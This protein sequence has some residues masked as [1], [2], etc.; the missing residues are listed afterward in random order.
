MENEAPFIT[1]ALCTHNH[2]DRLETTLGKINS[3]HA[4][5]LKWEFL[6]ID[7]AST[8][9]TARLLTSEIW[10]P[11][12]VNVRIIKEDKLGLSNARNR[13]VREARGDYVLFL[14]DDETPDLA[15][16][17]EYEKSF[18]EHNPDAVGGKISV[19]FEEGDRPRWLLDELLGFLG[20][21]DYGELRWLTEES[22]RICGGNF[23]I[24]RCVPDI[25]GDF[26]Q[27]L[28]RTGTS[29]VGGEDTDFYRRMVAQGC[30]VLWN[31]AAIIHHRI[32]ASKLR[33]SYFLDLHF[34]QG[35]TEGEHLRGQNSRLP[36]IY[37]YRQL[38]R[39]YF[40][41]YMKRLLSGSDFSLR[42]EMTAAYFKG[43]VIGWIKNRR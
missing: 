17:C 6:V 8:D 27:K 22:T 41:A 38:L 24:K 15:W 30:R 3:L 37:L 34:Q 13:A 10:R 1:V 16:I 9:G 28:G 36:P 25:V 18:L 20:K 39:A 33:R 26:N 2:A 29:N 14:D 5:K 21:L 12:N 40:R 23:A 43:M 7:N 19:V 35:R 4:P 11:S 32:Q 31:P 42:L